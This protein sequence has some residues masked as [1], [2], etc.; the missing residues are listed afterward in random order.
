MRV[1]LYVGSG[2]QTKREFK[3]QVAVISACVVWKC[4]ISC[5]DYVPSSLPNMYNVGDATIAVL[6]EVGCSVRDQCRLGHSD[7]L[8]LPCLLHYSPC[9]YKYTLNRPSLET[10][11]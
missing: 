2:Y 8:Q 6:F 3:F 9:S 11:L 4:G 1:I 10:G 7:Y 5:C